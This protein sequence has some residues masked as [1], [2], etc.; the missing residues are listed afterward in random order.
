MKY[1]KIY[2]Y[3]DCFLIYFY[4]KTSTDR[5]TKLYKRN[6]IFKLF[7]VSHKIAYTDIDIHMMVV[8]TFYNTVK[9]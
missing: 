5:W 8:E 2:L 6:D 4:N 9:L 1:F 7:I 3:Y